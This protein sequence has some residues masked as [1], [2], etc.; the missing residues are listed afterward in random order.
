MVLSKVLENNNQ[1]FADKPAY[2][3]RMGY[4]T[5]TFNYGQIYELAKKTALFLQSIGINKG[6]RVLI[7]APNSPYW[8]IVFWASILRG[9]I[10]VPINV[11]STSEM[12]DKILKQT[13]AKVI[14]KYKFFKVTEYEG[15]NVLN[16]DLLE[17]LINEFDQIKFIP[18]Q[19]FEDDIVQILYTSGTTGDPK[20]VLLS[21]KNIVSN[22]NVVK[23]LVDLNF[24]KD[25]FLSILPLTHIFEQTVGFFIPQ[26]YASHIVFMHSYAA[27]LDLM[28]KYKITKLLVVPEFLK[29]LS[30]KIR[31]EYSKKGLLKIFNY[32]KGISLEIKNMFIA[33]FLFYPVHK[34]LGGYLD[35]IVCGGAFLDS[36]L[37]LEWR[38]LG[39]E[40]LQGYG[41]T[42]TSPIISCNTY[43]DRKLGSVGKP[44]KSVELKIAEDGQILV[45]GPGVFLGY[46]KD[47]EKT[48]ESFTEDGFFKTGDI[49]KID[50]QGF[51]F[52]K[53]RKKYVIIGPGGQN[54]FPEDIEFEFNKTPGVKD[55]CVLGIPLK[56][57][58]TQIYV[59][60]LLND[61]TIN[62]RS[63]VDK[64][65]ENLASYQRVNDFMIWPQDDFPRSVTKKI[66]KEEV[67][68]LIMDK[69]AGKPHVKHY[70]EAS[71]LVKILSVISG[72]DID[73]IT[74]DERVVDK[75]QLDSLMRVELILR[76]EECFGVLIDESLI[77]NYTTVKELQEIIDNKELVKKRVLLK[78]W[79]R[80]WWAKL[81]RVVLQLI[82]ILIAKIF[83]KVKIEGLENLDGIKEQVV[84][85]PNHI[86]Y[87]D[88]LVFLMTIP[89]KYRNLISFAAAQDVLYE[90][91]NKFAWLA[92]LV[93]N[94]F[95]LPRFNGG[96]VKQGLDFMGEILDQ[97]Y[98]VV[99]FPEGKMSKDT[100]LLPLKKGA[101]LI[102]V[103]MGFPIVPVKII[104]SQDI[105]PY[106]KLFPIKSGNVIVRFGK[107]MFFKQSDSY[108]NVVIEIYNA[109]KNL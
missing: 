49:G 38:A 75:L 27:I 43:K 32:L 14:F 16:I 30:L 98:S 64:V 104:G 31:E 28:Q 89:N 76:I 82:S 7:F 52:L 77:N 63:L 73:K 48:E 42:E 10:L 81:I 80:S 1:N 45:K 103:E 41:L 26:V 93:F 101:G 36:D 92:E 35:T 11:Q 70:I 65:N 90:K 91:Y 3:M 51:L 109:I 23:N 4:I 71:P 18:S 99:V 79:P 102:S 59:A 58:G 69:Q 68:A 25:R 61:L 2:S 50:D 83:F 39:I 74:L 20:G 107:P 85:M 44:V 88:P 24:G 54:V 13:Q 22:I 86:S 60:L 67:L 57:G 34:K 78:K 8:G 29:V 66:K 95:P 94:S 56:S 47:K 15:V 55:S 106:S 96:N 72:F 9:S 87:S 84:F 37:E 6:D 21:H 105:V 46:Y 97:G 5:K 40:V 108:E 17:E 62:A 33:K 100:K 53:G 19:I 12:I